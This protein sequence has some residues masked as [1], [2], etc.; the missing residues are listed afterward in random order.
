MLITRPLIQRVKKICETQNTSGKISD[1][2]YIKY[3]SNKK[4][5]IVGPAGYLEGKGLGHY[6]DS[7]DIIVRINHALPISNKI[8]YG[9]RTDILY[10]ILSHRSKD[11]IHKDLVTKDE[12]KMWKKEGLKYL[13]SRHS[14]HSRRVQSLLKDLSIIGWI[15]LRQN[16]YDGIKNQISNKNPNTG[17][18]AIMHLLRLKPESVN[19]I[20]FDFY[21][22]GVYK[23]YGDIKE[24]ECADTVNSQWHDNQAQIDYLKKV[25]RTERRLFIDDA[26]KEILYKSHQLEE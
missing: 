16:F 20:G 26:L 17:V 19:V 13:V 9:E 5:I 24:G 12:I 18:I 8:D 25:L 1:I 6:I 14:F 2:E 15:P 22:S 3:I 4:V 10:H 11:G 7:F 21:R 23:G